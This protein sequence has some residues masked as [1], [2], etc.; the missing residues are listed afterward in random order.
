MVDISQTVELDK[1]KVTNALA[2]FARASYTFSKSAIQDDIDKLDK[3]KSRYK[4]KVAQKNIAS[5]RKYLEWLL[6]KSN[7]TI[8]LMWVF[9]RDTRK[10]ESLPIEMVSLPM[11]DMNTYDYIIL[12]KDKKLVSID[13]KELLSLMVFEASYRDLGGEDDT[14]S[15]EEM[16]NRLYEA[17]INIADINSTDKLDGIIP[18][19]IYKDA[20]VCMIED[21]RYVNKEVMIDYFNNEIDMPRNKKLYYRDWVQSSG[22]TSMAICLKDILSKASNS[23]VDLQIAGVTDTTISLVVD[24]DLD[25]SKLVDDVKVMIFGRKFRVVPKVYEY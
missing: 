12:D 20:L 21:S 24:R 19:T 25:V 18:S 10:I 16:D 17:G 14:I 6:K 22:Y 11:F 5:S 15:L 7:R 3:L 13:Y 23:R 9:D 4:G 8:N 1:S 2:K